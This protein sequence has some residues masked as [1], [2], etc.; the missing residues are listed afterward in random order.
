VY[1]RIYFYSNDDDGASAEVC[2]LWPTREPKLLFLM[3]LLRA[4]KWKRRRYAYIYIYIYMYICKCVERIDGNI[5][6]AVVFYR[7][8]IEENYDGHDKNIE[9]KKNYTHIYI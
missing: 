2:A 3:K 9:I 7:L 1:S 6:S 4:F 8:L 5:T